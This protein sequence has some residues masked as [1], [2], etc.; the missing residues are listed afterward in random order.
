MV[1]KDGIRMG[2]YS[3]STSFSTNVLFLFQA[4]I[5]DI[6]LHFVFS[7]FSSRH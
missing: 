6:T 5:Q 7:K 4:E 2:L 3:D 1:T